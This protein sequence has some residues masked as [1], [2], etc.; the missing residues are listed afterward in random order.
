MN[1]LLALGDLGLRCGEAGDGHAERAAGHIINADGVEELDG[2]GIS[3][4]LT[5]DTALQGRTAAA[6][7]V[8][9]HLDQLADGLG[10]DGLERI[11][12]QDLVTQ[13]VTHEGADIVTAEAEE[14]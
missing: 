8:H 1:V 12:I 10:V 2:L 9:T 4:V 13:V 5:T 11:G 3:T 6:T 7:T 14:D